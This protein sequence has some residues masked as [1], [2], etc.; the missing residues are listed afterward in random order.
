MSNRTAD[1]VAGMVSGC[2]MVSLSGSCPDEIGDASLERGAKSAAERTDRAKEPGPT[3]VI[4][5]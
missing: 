5:V 1:I 2:S 4:T 3:A